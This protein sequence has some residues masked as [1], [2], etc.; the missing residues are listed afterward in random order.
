[1]RNIGVQSFSNF[2]IF[3]F[4]QRFEYIKKFLLEGICSLFQLKVGV[5]SSS[6]K[7]KIINM[8]TEKLRKNFL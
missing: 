8:R 4:S 2:S 1:M 3:I 5:S 7:S 6:K